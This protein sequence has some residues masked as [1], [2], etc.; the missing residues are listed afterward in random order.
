MDSAGAIYITDASGIITDP[1]A[2]NTKTGTKMTLVS[3]MKK[4][5]QEVD[6]NTRY[7]G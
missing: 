6:V 2:V 4:A 3:R 7:E 5:L 1:E